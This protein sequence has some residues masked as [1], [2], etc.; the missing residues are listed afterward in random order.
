MFKS[1]DEISAI[2]EKLNDSVSYAI[3]ELT[4][5]S[6]ENGALVD[7][8]EKDT[9]ENTSECVKGSISVKTVSVMYSIEL[10]AAKKFLEGICENMV[11]PGTDSEAKK[12]MYID[13]LLEL[14]NTI[15]G[16]LMRKMEMVVGPFTIGIPLHEDEISINESAF[17]VKKYLVDDNN[18][19][20]V[21]ITKN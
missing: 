20:T 15:V 8:S 13:I 12:D 18:M 6:V 14:L 10:I 5:L 19:I 16:N 4:F 3:E 1:L 2:A 21:A 9:V 7:C 17:V 11:V